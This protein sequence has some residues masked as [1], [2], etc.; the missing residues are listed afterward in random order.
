MKTTKLLFFLSVVSII[1]FPQSNIDYIA[2]G[3]SFYK[4]FDLKN[5]A[6][7]YELAYK[8]NPSNYITLL[9][10]TR[11]YNDLGEDFYELKDEENAEDA[12][13]KAVKYAEV[14]YSKFPDSAHVYTLFAMS[15]GNLALY[16]GGNEKVKLAHKI[17]ENAEKAI[18]IDPNDYLAYIISSIYHR[19]IASLS[20]FERAFANTFFGKVP[21][22]SLEES[23]RL[24]LNALRLQPN[25]VIAMFHLSLTYQEMDN[26]LKEIEWLKKTIDAPINDF[27]D[28]YAKKKANERLKD[29]LD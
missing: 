14:F 11:I 17:K 1:S 20:W 10:V 9:K 23:E 29:L 13:N 28:K 15:Y 24:M 5:A 12:I 6:E 19:Q 22:G 2:K 8:Q 16:K 25:A 3:N 27:R 18:K 4:K 7:N 21:D 26:E